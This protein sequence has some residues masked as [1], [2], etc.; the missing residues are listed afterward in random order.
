MRFRVVRVREDVYEL[1]RA[2][3]DSRG[4]S[5]GEVIRQLINAYL[6]MSEV[7]EMLRQCLSRANTEVVKDSIREK[8][9]ELGSESSISLE[10]NPWVQ[11]I[12][13]RVVRNEGGEGRRGVGG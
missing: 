13:A 5:V 12:R 9:V 8:S 10:D 3:A 4:V 6:A 2:L 7:K 1:L 11:I